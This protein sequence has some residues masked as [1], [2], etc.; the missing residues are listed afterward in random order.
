MRNTCLPTR[1]FVLE[2]TL[3]LE[4]LLILRAYLVF[5]I[6]GFRVLETPFS[7]S[8][9]LYN[10]INTKLMHSRRWTGIQGKPLLFFYCPES[11]RLYLKTSFCFCFF[12][13]FFLTKSR[14]STLLFPFSTQRHN[15]SDQT[16]YISIHLVSL[17]CFEN[18]DVF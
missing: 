15:Y 9:D 17:N 7:F 6:S 8:K 4:S 10:H 12:L 2:Y 5:S 11:S 16:S 18:Q 3:L 13:F 14:F 1:A